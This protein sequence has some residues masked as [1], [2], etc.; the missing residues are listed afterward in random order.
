[1]DPLV[2]F[3]ILDW[4]RQYRRRIVIKFNQ[5]G[6]R[7]F[8]LIYQEWLHKRNRDVQMGELSIY[9]DFKQRAFL[10]IDDNQKGMKNIYFPLPEIPLPANIKGFKRITIQ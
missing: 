6:N 7:Q 8:S 9:S 2:W 10:A 5:L 4:L 1:M 3:D